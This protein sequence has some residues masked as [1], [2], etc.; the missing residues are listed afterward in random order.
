MSLALRLT[1]DM[2]T[3][4]KEK[5]KTRLSVIRLVRTAIKNAEI[6]TR[7]T[8]TDDDIL[9]VLGRE[10]KQ[11]RDSLEAFEQAG[12]TDL[13]DETNAEIRVLMEYLPQ[14][15]SEVEV[16]EIVR[17]VIQE[18]GAAGKSDMGKVMSALMPRV[19]G[20]ADGKTVNRIVN[21]LLS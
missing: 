13:A 18:T 11:R 5:D 15:L 10:L 9:A 7:K 16:T 19:K 3:A 8:L 2:K 21:Q 12:R 4:M 20:Q 6:D 14:Q 1:E 17:L